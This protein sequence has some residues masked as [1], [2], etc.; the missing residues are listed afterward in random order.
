L[1]RLEKEGKPADEVGAVCTIMV[2][3]LDDWLKIGADAQGLTFDPGLIDWAGV[4]V[5]KKAYQLFR[6]RGYRTRL[7]SAAFRNHYH[8]SELIGG[9]IVISPPYKWQLKFNASDIAVVPRIDKAVDDAIVSELMRLD[10][11]R[12]AYSEGGMTVEEFD[13]FAP[14]VRTLRQFAAACHDLEKLIRD[15]MLPEPKG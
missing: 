14:S 6:E 1:R 4:A 3:R 10:D 15:F 13:R 2:G 9:D 8:W 5:F 12:R 11:F 7:L